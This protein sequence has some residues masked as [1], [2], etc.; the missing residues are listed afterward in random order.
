MSSLPPEQLPDSSHGT[1]IVTIRMTISINSLYSR[2]DAV[3]DL[4]EIKRQCL[5]LDSNVLFETQLS[6]NLREIVI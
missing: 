5:D 3:A 1:I 4:Q 6:D 2:E